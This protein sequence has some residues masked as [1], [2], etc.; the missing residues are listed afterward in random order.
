[1]IVKVSI[2]GQPNSF[3]DIA[4]N[5]FF[6]NP[7]IISCDSF[8]ETINQ[9][10]NK[11]SDYAVVAIENSLYGTI[12]EVY[13]LILNNNVFISGEIYL[14]IEQNLIGLNG[15]KLNEIKEVHS[16]PV[17]LAQC[18]DFLN[19][20]LTNALRFEHHD[21]AGSVLDIKLW[22]DNSKA[23]I[24][25]AEAAIHNDM[26]ILAESIES[27]K[28]NYTRFVVVSRQINLQ[29]TTN[30]T[31]IVVQTPKDDK[32]GS[33]LSVLTK[34]AD[35]NINMTALHSRPIIGKAWHYMFYIDIEIGSNDN[36]YISIINDIENM[37]CKLTILG[38]YNSGLK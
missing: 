31:S 16:H 21:T 3:H 20:K 5:K 14:R 18:E 11:K 19:N 10:C 38:N 23:A 25:S 35:N 34:F 30:K 1:M 9:L 26:Q 8:S 17:A 27:N 36:S 7:T 12:N 15:A 2:Q 33:L 24:A 4:T 6:D 32:S 28:Q 22:N 37:G 29:S 13:D